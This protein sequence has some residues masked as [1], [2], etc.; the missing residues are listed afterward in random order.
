MASLINPSP[1]DIALTKACNEAE[2]LLHQSK[3][4]EAVEVMKPFKD[5]PITNDNS[6]R[7]LVVLFRCCLVTEDPMGYMYIARAIQNGSRSI[8]FPMA[9]NYAALGIISL[10]KPEDMEKQMLQLDFKAQAYIHDFSH[11]CF[12]SAPV[13]SHVLRVL[14]K[15]Y[16]PSKNAS[17][18][19]STQQ[20]VK[21]FKQLV[22][23]KQSEYALDTERL[24][25]LLPVRELY[26]QVF[27]AIAP[28]APAENKS[29]PEI[30]C[31]ENCQCAI[32][33]CSLAMV[34]FIYKL[35]CS[36]DEKASVSSEDVKRCIEQYEKW[37]AQKIPL[38]PQLIEK[39]YDQ[40]MKLS[41]E[42]EVSLS[43]TL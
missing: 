6:I 11:P 8:Y 5:L 19:T 1:T 15:Y 10:N 9:L 22:E 20:D 43:N 4:Q 27:K 33:K 24:L 12:A 37:K 26:C 34:E 16:A 18:L 42:R 21:I 38:Y 40:L 2:S 41:T 31:H 7:A 28:A 17:P 25:S 32:K 13:W 30:G 39:H 14:I 35:E 29:E 36:G 3:V 23:S